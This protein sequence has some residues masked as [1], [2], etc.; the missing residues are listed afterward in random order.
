MKNTNHA[1]L[2]ESFL[3]HASWLISHAGAMDESGESEK[4]N[5]EWMKAARC[6]EEVACLL[7]NAGRETEAAVQRVSRLS[8]CVHCSGKA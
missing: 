6:A 1:T 2:I 3:D 7:E 8:S 4:A 5:S